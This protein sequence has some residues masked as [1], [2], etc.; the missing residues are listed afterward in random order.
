MA[1][2][3]LDALGKNGWRRVVFLYVGPGKR[4]QWA[5]RL[6]RPGRRT[7]A[8]VTVAAGSLSFL[9]SL[10]VWYL[11]GR[12]ATYGVFWREGDEAGAWGGPTLA[13]AWITHA[14]IAAALVA[15]VMWLLVPITTL[16][17]RGLPRTPTS[18]FDPA[19]C[20]DSNAA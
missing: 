20:V 10:V 19:E 7:A 9:L 2:N 8:P 17:I 11:I 14:L 18:A 4:R 1:T 15:V 13:G 12:I 6:G 5:P 16:I 3:L